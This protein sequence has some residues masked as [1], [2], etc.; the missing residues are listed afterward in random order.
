MREMARVWNDDDKEYVEKFKENTIVIPAKK[1]IVMDVGE[2]NS[3]LRAFTPVVRD[4]KEQDVQPKRLRME[5]FKTKE[6]LDRP[7]PKFICMVDNQE[8]PNQ[9]AYD[10]H[11]KENHMANIVDK[12]SRDAF[13]DIEQ[14]L[15]LD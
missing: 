1:F 2:A 5:R 6:R 13:E 15:A 14:E 9:K 10:V 11:V 7:K 12:E 8:F 3:F 4:S